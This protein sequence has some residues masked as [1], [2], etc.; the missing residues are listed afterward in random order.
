M[1]RKN[2]RTPRNT[3]KIFQVHIKKV[4]LPLNFRRQ[5]VMKTAVIFLH[6]FIYYMRR[7]FFVSFLLISIF[8]F[9]QDDVT[10]K[11]PPKE[12]VDLVLAK[13]VPGVYLDS[14]AEWMFMTDRSDFPTIEDMAQPELRIGGLRI[15]PKNFSQSRSPY[16]VS[17]QLQHIP[18]K[19]MYAIAGLPQQLKAGNFSW[20]PNEKKF[21][22]TNSNLD[23]VDL[24]VIDLASKTAK[25]VNTGPLNTTT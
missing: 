4:E 12:I 13:P 9:A 22:F 11:T 6:Q 21:A 1:S 24:Y 25:K 14:K 3:N 8:S 2:K 7:L 17:I 23:R 15:N 20:S 19:T 5:S 18:T 16:A 10:Y